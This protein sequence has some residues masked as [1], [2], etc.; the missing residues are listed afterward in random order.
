MPLN[1]TN[2]SLIPPPERNPERRQAV[3][4]TALPTE[5]P[6]ESHPDLDRYPVPDLVDAFIDDQWHALGAVRAASSQIAEAVAHAVP[7]I[8]AGG[9]LVYVGAGTSGRLGVL[10]ASEMPPT[11]GTD[12]ELV[13]GVIAGG[14]EALLRAQEG[15]EDRPDDA[16]RHR[17]AAFMIQQRFLGHED[18][19]CVITSFDLRWLDDN[20]REMW[21]G[22]LDSI[23]EK[24][25]SH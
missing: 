2:T 23:A 20:F 18:G 12:P 3:P 17:F 8:A 16:A 24:E 19:G 7:R 11:Y 21:Q 5:L 9:R 1:K 13:Q 25:A 22:V 15:A 14:Y 10:D 6:S 4:V